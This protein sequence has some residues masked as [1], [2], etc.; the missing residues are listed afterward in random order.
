[1]RLRNIQKA[2]D[3]E[4]RK[5]LKET[6]NLSD[7]Q[8]EKL[9]REEIIERAPFYFFSRKKYQPNIWLR[10]SI[11]LYPFVWLILFIGL[12][13]NYFITGRWGYSKKWNFILNW[14]DKIGL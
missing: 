6:L 10:L 1:M 12:P 8:Q 7:Y 11:V 3:Y 4:V 13:F 9:W 5:W 2:S 14:V